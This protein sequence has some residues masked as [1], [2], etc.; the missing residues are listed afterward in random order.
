[1]TTTV[2]G[3]E[4]DWLAMTL[5]VPALTPVTIPDVLPTVATPVLSLA[6]VMDEMA[7]VSPSELSRHASR[8]TVL[9]TD[10]DA[11]AAEAEVMAA[12]AEA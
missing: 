8:S 2:S 12:G 9:P 6:Q 5:V 11:V 10:T 1:M 7:M 3:R 4:P